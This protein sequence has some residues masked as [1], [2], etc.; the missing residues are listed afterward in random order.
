MSGVQ[1]VTLD[2]FQALAKRLDRV[3][4]ELQNLKSDNDALPQETTRMKAATALSVSLR[5]VDTL[6]KQGRLKIR[7]EGAK[8]GKVLVLTSSIRS[9]LLD[10]GFSRDYID[11]KL[12]DTLV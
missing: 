5:T 2:A 6:I 7:R 3:E 10:K 8:Q 9:R 1:V 11:K 4:N 12:F